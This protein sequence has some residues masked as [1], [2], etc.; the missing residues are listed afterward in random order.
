MTAPSEEERLELA[1]KALQSGDYL[2]FRGDIYEI[3]ALQEDLIM[4]SDHDNEDP[5]QRDACITLDDFLE[6]RESK[7]FELKPTFDNSLEDP[8]IANYSIPAAKLEAIIE[9]AGALF[10]TI[11]ENLDLDRY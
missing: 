8:R 4:V 5:D 2:E 10:E 9:S 6:N 11:M 1:K 7:V 3:E